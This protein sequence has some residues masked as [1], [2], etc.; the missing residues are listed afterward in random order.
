MLFPGRQFTHEE[1]EPSRTP[2]LPEGETEGPRKQLLTIE[3]ELSRIPKLPKGS[4][5]S[6]RTQVLSATVTDMSIRDMIK[7]YW[8]EKPK[9]TPQ[10]K[11]TE[12]KLP[13]HQGRV[14]IPIDPKIQQKILELYHD[15]PISG[16]QGIT[17]TEELVS[18]GY[19]WINMNNYIRDYIKG[20]KTCQRA[21]KKTVRGHG[22]LQPL[23]KP[24]GPWQWTE[25]N[26]V[27]PLPPLRGGNAIYIVVDQFSKYTYFIPCTD[28]ESA[29][30]LAKLHERHVWSQEGLPRIHST[31]RGPQF[32]AEFT[33]ELYQSL[34]IDQRMSTA[35]HPQTQGQVENLN[36]WLETYLRMFI[37]HRQDDWMDFVHKAQFTWNNHYHSSI[38]TMPFFA[39]KVRHPILTDIPA[40][41]QNQNKR[42]HTRV[43]V[44]KL[45][46]EMINKAQEAQRK[47]YDR[48][49]KE[50][51]VFKKG[52]KVW[53]ETI[54][55]STN[56]PSP[57]LDWKRI[58]PL[59]VK[60]QSQR[61]RSKEEPNQHHHQSK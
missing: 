17:G 21:K 31:D 26:L 33:K 4:R 49:K 27:G 2:K 52:D 3:D 37:S 34:G 12:D 41:V 40:R 25:S 10:S 7:E 14:H 51:P 58:G 29:Q 48:W 38:G 42:L 36:G 23:L 1:D 61:T 5:E 50:P 57:K 20:C 30:S 53:L 35:Y 6:S 9:E 15:S 60:R 32:R 59:V 44:D 24:E 47:A 55:L 18:R 28:K 39:S 22:R 19:Y 16:H 46:S 54:N 56:R 8:A 45:I 11:E 43:E 13:L